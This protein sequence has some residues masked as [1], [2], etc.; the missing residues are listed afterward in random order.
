MTDYD[1]IWYWRKRLPDRKGQPCK[2]L[3]RGSMNSILIEFEDGER[4][5]TSRYAVRKAITA[6]TL[7]EPS[8]DVTPSTHGI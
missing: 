2:V 3:A 6:E 8:G 4:F 5:V 1:Y 7:G